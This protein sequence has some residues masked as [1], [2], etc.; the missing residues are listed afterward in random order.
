MSQAI[1]PNK[2]RPSK[3]RQKRSLRP[4]GFDELGL[5]RALDDRMLP[6]LVA[7]MAFLG[8]LG[9]AGFVA[10]A[11]LAHHWQDGAASTLTV[12][13]PDPGLAAEN[14]GGSGTRRDRV[15]ALLARMPGV[16]SA[17]ALSD[18][19]LNE[20]LRPW[21][22][23][24]AGSMER[25]TLPLPGVIQVRLGSPPPALDDLERRLAIAVPRTLVE[26]HQVWIGRLA[27][28]ARSLQAC[29]GGALVVVAGVAAAVVA[30]A[31]RAGLVQRRQAIEIVHGLGATDG[32]IAGRFAR[33]TTRLA[34]IGGLL[35]AV[36]ALPVLLGLA[37]L[38]APFVSTGAA[39]AAFAGLP[40]LP[41]LLWFGLPALPVAAGA[42][43]FVT[44][45]ATVRSWLRRL[46]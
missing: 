28:L 42:I 38:G 11:S 14:P 23:A 5:R 18:D 24:G 35:G 13:V 1:A 22:G 8:A 4:P 3:P 31:T 20:L 17:R 43:G 7:A 29:A 26:S 45:Q 33:R 2:P 21:I 34:A 44:A 25:L 16:V 9:L 27:T 36:A 6:A 41:A 39:E 40:Q 46:P 32:Y 10:A 37:R 12:Q 30:V 15:L 19:E